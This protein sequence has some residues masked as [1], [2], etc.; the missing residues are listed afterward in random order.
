MACDLGHHEIASL[1]LYNRSSGGS[2]NPNIPDTP[3]EKSPL[4]T[5]CIH[6]HLDLVGLLMDYKANPDVRDVDGYY[7]IQKVHVTGH[8]E[9]VRLLLENGADPSFLVDLSLQESCHHGYFEHV[10]TIHEVA[11]FDEIQLGIKE[12]CQCGYPETAMGIII[13][14]T[15]ENIQKECYDVWN[16]ICHGL[17][18]ALYVH[19]VVTQSQE[20]N[21]LWQ[22]FNSNDQQKMEQM[23]KDGHDPNVTNSHGTPLIHACLKN[24]MTQAVFAL[25]NSPKIDIKQKDELGRTVLFY[26]LDWFRVMHDGKQ[27]CMFDFLLEHGAEVLP[28][29]F[30]RTLL[31][32]WQT[33]PL[34]GVQGLSLGN[35]TN[36]VAIDQADYKGQTALHIAVLENKPDKV[37]ELLDAGGNPEILDT[38][39]ISPFELAKQRPG[40]T[41]YQMLSERRPF[42]GNVSDSVQ[43]VK[44]AQNVRFSNEYKMEHRITATLSKL[45]HQANQNSS[46]NQ[47][48]D[49]YKIPLVIFKNAKL[50]QEFKSFR[51]TVLAFMR[52]IGSAISREDTLFGFTPVLSGSCSEGTKVLEMNEADVLCWFQHSDWQH[53]DIKTHEAK[54]YA[55]MKVESRKLAVKYP[56]LFREDCLSVYGIFQRFYTLMRKH[57]AHILKKSK[58]RNLY[59]L[60]GNRILHSDHAICPLHLAWSGK[61]LRWQE[62]SLDVVPAIPVSVEKLPG[63]LKSP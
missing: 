59:I 18:S 12:A 2:A 15:N 5:A 48:M 14:M 54:N 42:D 63:E 44:E 19:N 24:K 50:I 38:N 31:H 43:N 34:G 47:F 4:W 13:N 35:L 26:T 53:I 9:V 40:D 21:P 41:I 37:R 56:S 30:G 51:S 46:S 57:I 45:F 17:S 52:D 3:P 23:I 25:C 55:Y 7:L 39:K 29:N 62:F 11:A 6:N 10:Q 61:I 33:V 27:C 32:A 1:L 22:Y 60:D 16:Q 20:N 58:Y 36:H 28:D 8:Y 49:K